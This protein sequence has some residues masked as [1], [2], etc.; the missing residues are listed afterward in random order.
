MAFLVWKKENQ[1][2]GWGCAD[3]GFVLRNPRKRESLGEY[4]AAIRNEFDQ[5]ICEAQK[6]QPTLQVVKKA[7]KQSVSRLAVR[8]RA[9]F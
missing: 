4:V 7:A 5:H 9:Y 1:V 6:R 8:M 2:R 3:C